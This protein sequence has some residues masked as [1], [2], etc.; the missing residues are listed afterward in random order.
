MRKLIHHLLARI[1]SAILQARRRAFVSA[2]GARCRCDRC[3]CDR[4]ALASSRIGRLLRAV[5]CS[6][7][8][9]SLAHGGRCFGHVWYEYAG[10]SKDDATNAKKFP[11]NVNF[12]RGQSQTRGTVC[13]GVRRVHDNAGLAARGWRRGDGGAGMHE[14]AA[15][16]AVLRDVQE[17]A[18]RAAVPPRVLHGAGHVA[19]ARTTRH[20]GQSPARAGRRTVQHSTAQHST[21]Q[22]STAQHSTGVE[23]SRAEP[24]RRQVRKGW[25]EAVLQ[26]ALEGDFWMKGSAM[27]NPPRFNIG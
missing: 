24:A 27:R 10:L 6:G 15:G 25:L 9:R 14:A 3:R 1:T 26:D 20:N 21:A 18:P 17:R 23:P 19:R 12:F 4:C 11:F 16:D 2:T 22:H 7:P 5:R 8:L 13:G